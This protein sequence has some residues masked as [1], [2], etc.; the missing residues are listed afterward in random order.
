M[1]KLFF[2]DGRISFTMRAILTL[3]LVDLKLRF[4][5]FRELYET[6]KRY[7][8]PARL[9]KPIPDLTS[10]VC[11]AVNRASLLYVSTT[12]CLQRSA[13]LVL[14]LRRFGVNAEFVIGCRAL[15]FASH[16]WVEVERDVVNDSADVRSVY[17]IVDR[18]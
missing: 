3:A 9:R 10:K 14:M 1:K 4:F 16:A 13:A 15:P 8:P 6:V 17:A 7:R 2:T 5:G 12:T 18:L 11:T